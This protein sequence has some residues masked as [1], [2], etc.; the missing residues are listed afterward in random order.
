MLDAADV[1]RMPPY[2]VVSMVRNTSNHELPF[3]YWVGLREASIGRVQ[4]RNL[5]TVKRIQWA[6]VCEL[7]IDR[8]RQHSEGPGGRAVMAEEARLRAYVIT[9]FGRED[10]NSL[11]D[12]S[13]LFRRVI[14]SIGAER[15]EVTEKA[16]GWQRLTR[17][18]MLQLRRV[19]NLVLPFKD[20]LPLLDLADPLRREVEGWIDVLP[21]LP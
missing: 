14:A 2:E 16:G 15:R 13:V 12:A 10:N 17:E 21:L 11:S 18:E 19:K 4:D 6:A 9:R 1:L 8:M 5:P 7:A 3:A 20:V